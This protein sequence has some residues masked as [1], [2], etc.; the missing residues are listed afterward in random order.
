MSAVYTL[1]LRERH[2]LGSVD[3]PFI[4]STLAVRSMEIIAAAEEGATL[5][6][7]AGYLQ[8]PAAAK[9][10]GWAIELKE[11]GREHGVGLVFGIDWDDEET[12]GMPYRPRS[13]AFAFDRGRKRLWAE[14]TPPRDR[15]D[16]LAE[17]SV[18][19][20]NRRVM[21]LLQNEIFRS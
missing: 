1:T 18:T 15:K 10:D 5:M 19:I 3:D 6:L 21:V 17:R 20:G 8:A 12:W 13:F 14:S 2:G 7:P 9:R 16:S 4:R 11:E